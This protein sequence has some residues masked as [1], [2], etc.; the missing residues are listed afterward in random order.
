MTLRT[1]RVARMAGPSRR[2]R[3]TRRLGRMLPFLAGV[4]VVALVV[5]AGWVMYQRFLASPTAEFRV[6]GVDGPLPGAVIEGPDGPIE[7]AGEFAAAVVAFEPPGE[8]RVTAPGY[9]PALFEVAGI[10]D[11]G[12]LYLQLEPRVLKGLIT[13]PGGTPLPQVNVAVGD[14]ELVTDED[15][16]FEVTAASPG[17]ITAWR[18]AWETASAEWDG[19]SDR[20][21]LTMEPFMVRGLRVSGPTAG[22]PTEFD[23]LLEYADETAIN[24]LVFDTK[25]ESGAV[26]YESA[27]QE[28][29][30]IGAIVP[31]YDP[32]EVLAKAKEHDLYTITRIVTF[33]DGFRAPARPQ[34]AIRDTVSGD[35]WTNYRGLGWMDATDRESWTYPIA[36]AEEACEL[37]FDEVQF[38]YVRF[39]S[40]GDVGRM[41]FDR[42]INAEVR[43]ETISGFL[44]EA[45]DR[46]H[47]MGCAVSADVFGIVLSVPDDQGLGQRVEELS[48]SVDALSPMVYP[49]HYSDGWLGFDSP[50]D[51]PA[52]VVGQALDAGVPKLEGAAIMRPWIQAFYYDASQMEEQYDQAD[53][54]GV[55]YLLWNA[56]SEFDVNALPPQSRYADE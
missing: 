9:Y 27:V 21:E 22:N 39:P 35:I 34:H 47:E 3:R 32:E 14:L 41:G 16:A 8:I 5:A 28:A 40:D 6:L 50:N 43:I 46:L 53:R 37:G 45:R 29:Q 1:Q 20:F 38:D 18:P 24:A 15:G 13:R 17:T 56:F 51:H 42:E 31:T 48:Y 11:D 44:A 36:L 23:R 2:R 30:D 54:L 4:A 7:A 25:E 19:S 55:G 33:Q 10:P 12:P 26:F 52:E 49:S